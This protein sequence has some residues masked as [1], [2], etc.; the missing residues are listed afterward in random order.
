MD[1]LIDTHTK[2]DKLQHPFMIKP[3]SK[4]RIEGNC[5][6]SIKNIYKK[7]YSYIILNGAKRM[8][9]PSDQEQ[10]KE[11]YSCNSYST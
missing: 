4:L 3:L 9:Y 11:V 10:G 2:T 5:L 1:I 6:N 7:L 8:L